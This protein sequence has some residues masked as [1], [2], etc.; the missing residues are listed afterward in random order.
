MSSLDILQLL[1]LCRANVVLLALSLLLEKF[2]KL[3]SCLSG[4]SVVA[5]LF[6]LASVLFQQSQEVEHLRVSLD[7]YYP[8]QLP[9]FRV[10]GVLVVTFDIEVLRRAALYDLVFHLLHQL[11][12]LFELDFAVRVGI[13]VFNELSNFIWIS[14]ETT[15]DSFEVLNFD[16]A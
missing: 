8:S 1:L 13:D 5:L 12:K 11:Q 6:T 2:F 16:M 3:G 14:L 9:S 10:V 15:H 7:V 4:L